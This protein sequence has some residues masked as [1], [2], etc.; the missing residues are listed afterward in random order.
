MGNRKSVRGARFPAR[1][2]QEP[3]DPLEFVF[4]GDDDQPSSKYVAIGLEC[5][6][7][8]LQEHLRDIVDLG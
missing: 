5:A 3:Q 6:M 1:R 8:A 7:P 2:R 4:E